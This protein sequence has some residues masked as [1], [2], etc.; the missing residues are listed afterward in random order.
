MKMLKSL[1][2]LAAGAVTVSVFAAGAADAKKSADVKK[3]PDAKCAASKCAD[4]SCKDAK[5]C[6][7]PKQG[8]EVQVDLWAALPDTV[9]TINGKPVMKQEVIAEFTKQLPDGKVPPFFTPEFVQQ[10]APMLVEQ[11]VQMKL[12]DQAMAK[13]K[14]DA[15]PEAVKG[16]LNDQI[17]KMP[18]DQ[19][20]MMSQQ[21][22]MQN[23]TIGQ[24]VDELVAK[25][26]VCKGIARGM[27]AE[28]TFLK[29]VKVD[30]A[31][32]KK[33]YDANPQMFRNPADAEGTVRASHILVMTGAKA[34]D[35]EKKAALEKINNIKAQ[36]VKDPKQFE[37]LAKSE[38][39]CPS[40]KRGGSLGAFG[41]GQ[42]VPEFEKVAFSLKPGEISEVVTTQYGYHI[43]RRDPPQGETVMPFDEVKQQLIEALQ[44]RKAQEAEKNFIDN[45][46]K[47]NKVQIFVKP[48]QAAP[49]APAAKPA[50]AKKN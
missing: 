3:C 9:A 47:E 45:L 41:K 49:A 21:L 5:C 6:P 50:P 27:F 40:G 1:T 16:F 10:I 39:Q 8:A 25:P 43:I 42:M 34:T 20:K 4:K 22:A 31:E 24:Y 26:E 14:F 48:A 32:A 28:A 13:A 7:A 36:L 11:I 38:S 44:S 30:E 29:G 19:V 12:M 46:R 18:Q 37:A 33:F 2:L 35:A 23:K 15:N 17:R